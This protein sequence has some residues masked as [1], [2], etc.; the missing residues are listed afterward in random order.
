MAGTLSG[1]PRGG[2]SLLSTRQESSAQAQFPFQWEQHNVSGG[3]WGKRRLF[4]SR[5]AGKDA[6]TWKK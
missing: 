2:E 5:A 6:E 1:I 4:G 3:F